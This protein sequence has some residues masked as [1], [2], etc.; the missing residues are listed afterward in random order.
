MKKIIILMFALLLVTGCA[1]EAE[2]E[3][4]AK[5]MAFTI[6]SWHKNYGFQNDN[7]TNEDDIKLLDTWKSENNSLI[8][9]SMESSYFVIG[10]TNKDNTP[11]IFV[12]NNQSYIEF[13]S[14]DFQK[15][16]VTDELDEHQF[17]IETKTAKLN[18]NGKEIE[19]YEDLH[20]KLYDIQSDTLYTFIYYGIEKKDNTIDVYYNS[21][22]NPDFKLQIRF[23]Y[24]KNKIHSID[25]AYQ[26]MEL[27]L[28]PESELPE[29]NPFGTIIL[30]LIFV[31][32]IGG[33]VYLVIKS[34]KARRI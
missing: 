16:Y 29:A 12:R 34:I 32:L 20:K 6:A 27:N 14:L 31:G 8:N 4:R 28:E 18:Y 2:L 22:Q 25:T 33:G 24:T 23:T 30:I 10:T 9:L 26:Y 19:I 15:V 3:N 1:K 7:I 11:G 13:N 5:D 17:E 21:L